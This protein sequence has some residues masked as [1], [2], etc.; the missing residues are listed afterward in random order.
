VDKKIL[1]RIILIVA[2][3]GL[4]LWSLYP[5]GEK[6]NYGLDLSGGIHLVLQVQTDDAIKA[7]LD[8]AAQRLVS[9]AADEGLDL[10]QAG[11]DI[12]DLSFRVSVP[13]DTDSGALRE[14]ADSWVPG[15]SVSPGAGTWTFSLPP[16]MDRTVRDMA[17]RSS[18]E[19]IW[20]RVDQFGVA[21]PV[22]QRQGLE[23]DRILVQLPGVDDPARVKDLISST[24]FLEF[25]EVTGGP[26]PDRQSLLSTVG[27]FVP[28]DSEILPGDREGLDGSVIGTDYY[29]LKKAAIISGQE[30]R[31]ARRSQDEYGQPVVNF[32]TQPHAADKFGQFTGSHIGTRMAI[33][34]DERVISAPVIESRIPGEGRITGNFTI[35]EA[36]DLSLKLRA[37]ALPATIT[38]L[39]ER[40]VGPSL[41][42][43]SV[44]RGVRA[45]VSGLLAVMVFM[46]V[47]YRL[48]GLNANVALILNLIILLGAM[49]YFGA[50]LTL[51][52]IAGVILTIGMAVDANVLIFERI[53]EE[54]RVGKTVRAAIDTGFARAF[55]TI[56]DANLTT[57]IAALFLFNFGTGP[58]KG[59]AVTLSIGILASVFTAV[60]VSRTLY[61]IVLGGRERVESLSI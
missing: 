32:A 53:R 52:G 45:A 21:E 8:D 2:V 50:T 30:L 41:G 36:E 25:Q 16:N 54:L 28:P 19:T 57:L 43:D 56:L 7:E 14:V 13:A 9:R 17:V 60:F 35:E 37:G 3:V 31:S 40:T 47:Y 15:Y 5:P 11:S 22:I 18:L 27:G 29:L 38:Y 42:R 39:E 55:G 58:V 10:E 4:C 1:W 12:E 51:P 33:V 46:L 59:F 26:L 24:A 61:M 34:L 20:N 44:V 49:A 6:I 48:S 23:S